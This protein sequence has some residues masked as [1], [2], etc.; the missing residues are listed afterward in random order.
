MSPNAPLIGGLATAPSIPRS[1]T[2]HTIDSATVPRSTVAVKRLQ[3][4][5]DTRNER[6]DRQ[7]GF[8]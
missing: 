3:D 7:K 1:A 5:R 4:G 2:S 8:A 6:R